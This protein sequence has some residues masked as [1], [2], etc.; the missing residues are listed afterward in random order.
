M[1]K[2]IIAYIALEEFKSEDARVIVSKGDMVSVEDWSSLSPIYDQGK[3]K[4][5]RLSSV[6]QEAS[7]EAENLANHLDGV[8]KFNDPLS[9]KGV[10]KSFKALKAL[11]PIVEVAEAKTKTTV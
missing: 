9:W 6:I 3:F 1:E 7:R 10:E 8:A 2:K 5:L 4:P 11:M